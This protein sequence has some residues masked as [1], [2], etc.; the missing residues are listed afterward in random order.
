VICYGRA[1]IIEDIEERKKALDIFNR[2]FNP[3]AEGISLEAAKKCYAVE[4]EIAE[5]TGRQEREGKCTYWRA[6]F[7]TQQ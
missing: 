6:R 1:R 5:M 3:N 2:C 7:E 4:I